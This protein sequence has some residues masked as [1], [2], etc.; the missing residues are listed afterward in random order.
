MDKNNVLMVKIEHIEGL[1]INPLY[2]ADSLTYKLT[3]TR[4]KHLVKREENKDN[5]G[6]NFVS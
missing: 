5:V 2:H 3:G 1:R 4:H 6:E